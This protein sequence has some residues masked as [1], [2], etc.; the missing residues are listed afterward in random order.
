MATLT[1]TK[2]EQ[3]S[4]S[5]PLLDSQI[6]A[7]FPRDL[8]DREIDQDQDDFTDNRTSLV[9][10]SAEGARE[11]LDEQSIAPEQ[12]VSNVALTEV[13]PS[14]VYVQKS[15]LMTLNNLL[16]EPNQWNPIVPD[17]RHSMPSPIQGPAGPSTD[18]STSALQTLVTNL[19]NHD[20]DM[21]ETGSSSSDASLL[22]EL[23]VRVDNLSDSL[24]ESDAALAKALVS[25]LSDLNRISELGSTSGLPAQ[26][27]VM[28]RT[29]L[30]A[31][32][33]IDV[34]DTLTR[35]LSDLQV[36]RLSSQ[37]DIPSSD[38]PPRLA[39]EVALLWSRI[40]TELEN[41]VALCKQRTDALPRFTGDHLPPQYDLE[42]YEEE[43]LPDYDGTGRPSL[44]ET[45]TK[46]SSPQQASASRATDEKMRLDLEA[47]AL[48][49]DRLYLVAP[50]L[51]NQRVELKSSK[52]AQMEKASREGMSSARNVSRKGKERDVRDLENMLELI[53]KA[54]ERTLKDQ[55][56]ILEGGM[57]SRLEKARK[58]DSA[59]KEA[60]VEQLIRHSDAGRIHGQD[61]TLPPKVK[62]PHAL[63]TL[64][65]FMRE[66]LPLS[67]RQKGDEA[68]L[69]LPE[70]VKEPIPPSLI[71]E[72]EDDTASSEPDS[73]SKKR[74][75]SLS[76][77]PLAWLR[78][79]SAKLGQQGG[80]ILKKASSK[81]LRG[82]AFDIVY[83]AEN[84]ENLQHIL[85]FFRTSIGSSKTTA[86]V[87]AEVVPSFL[88][89][90]PDAG[91]HLVIKSGANSSLPLMLPA[92][93]SPGK[94]EVRTQST[95]Y[96]IKLTTQPTSQHETTSPPL[97]DATQLE[98]LKPTSF[99]CSSC[100]LPLIQASKV[101][102]YKDLPSEHWEELVEAWM[103]HSDQKLH[104]QV[105]SHGRR[106]FSPS[107][108]QALV[109]G[110]Y[111]LFEGSAIHKNNLHVSTSNEAKVSDHGL[112][113]RCICG[114]VIGRRR[115]KTDSD[116]QRTTYRIL[117]YAVRP[118]SLKNEP[119]KV[120][121]TA[122]IVED[123]NEFVQAHA[124][125][126]FVIRDEEDE[127]PRILIWLFKPRIR[128][129]YATPQSRLMPK[130]ASIVAA[131]VLYKLL[132]PSDIASDLNTILKRYPGFPQ[133]EY[134]SYPM[135]ICHRLANLLK[136]SN[137]AYPESLRTMTGLEVGWLQRV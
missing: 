40:D 12:R 3:R 50:Q 48:A 89:R 80:A 54:T 32:P 128:I 5:A 135:S 133:A 84:H 100:S 114:A 103:C 90:S 107:V 66:A 13:M 99:L 39:V 112:L 104:D 37:A 52:R 9:E 60:F 78:S 22:R 44:D 16:S 97:L 136:E 76:A 126:R 95:H 87:Q 25:L 82:S 17:R 34:F 36:E 68:L 121:L 88:D 108:G 35:Q 92:Q 123:M 98:S 124:S 72:D 47:V 111:I 62:D 113:T 127:K 46:V 120:P 106:G 7:P 11:S 73:K 24:T 10:S 102:M 42:D 134:L 81:N 125:Y 6:P 131:K 51:H 85:V 27:L 105:A 65:E 130:S 129:A 75:R 96:E 59:R 23:R 69:T 118:V 4:I 18:T 55:S 74:H 56:V 91:D 2:V 101:H 77:P 28:E 116:G 79:S 109:G 14:I 19:R 45:K 132:T 94:K 41:V 67:E 83:V 26:P 29:T 49:I 122:F 15:C 63:L 115:E 38:T 58:K 53:G 119:L 86:D 64:P 1:R 33:P 21:I 93:T 61:A 137:A 31:P 43:P 117:K 70:F 8:L 57:Q 110:S 30:D 20:T 71:I